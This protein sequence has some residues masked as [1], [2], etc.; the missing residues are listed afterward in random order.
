MAE[1]KSEPKIPMIGFAVSF[2]R[3]DNSVPVEY[4]VNQVYEQLHLFD[5]AADVD[6]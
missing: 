6:V 2:P 1:V 3:D 5:D 4:L